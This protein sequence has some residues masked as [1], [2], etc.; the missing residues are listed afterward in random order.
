MLERIEALMRGFKEVLDNIAHDLKT[1]SPGCATAPRRRCARVK[2]EAEYRA[3]L[4]GTIED[5][6]DLIRNLQRAVD[7]RAREF[8]PSQH[9]DDEFDARRSRARDR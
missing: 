7:D 2:G 4:E 6:D 5:S 9:A 8:G 3:A 1:R